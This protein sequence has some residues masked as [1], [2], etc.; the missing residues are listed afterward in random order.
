MESDQHSEYG[1]L[2][3]SKDGKISEPQEGLSPVEFMKRYPDL[4]VDVDADGIITGI[5]RRAQDEYDS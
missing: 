5:H 4:E 3:W 1:I 2:W